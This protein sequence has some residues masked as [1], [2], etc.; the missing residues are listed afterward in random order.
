MSE[1]SPGLRE[2]QEEI[3]SLRRTTAD[4]ENIHGR[5]NFGQIP[6]HVLDQCPLTTGGKSVLI[7]LSRWWY[8]NGICFAS[9]ATM[10]RNS[11]NYKDEALKKGADELHRKGV[12]WKG[13]RMN[14]Y[15]R[16][17]VIVPYYEASRAIDALRAGEIPHDII[18]PHQ[19]TELADECADFFFGSGIGL[20][21]ERL[22]HPSLKERLPNPE[23]T[24]NEDS[25]LMSQRER[26]SLSHRERESRLY[27]LRDTGEEILESSSSP[28]GEDYKSRT[29]SHETG[30]RKSLNAHIEEISGGDRETIDRCHAFLSE[31]KRWMSAQNR[32][33]FNPRGFLDDAIASGNF[34]L[35]DEVAEARVD[36]DPKPSGRYEA[37]TL[38]GNRTYH[39]LQFFSSL[40]S[41]L[42][43]D[44]Q[45]RLRWNRDTAYFYC[46]SGKTVSVSALIPTGDFTK[47]LRTAI[48]DNGS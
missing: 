20:S 1:S 41:R 48:E 47:A 12:I 34:C 19:Q 2:L 7:E 33:M 29:V 27:L 37:A 15:G 30:R 32:V 31:S 11:R 35:R 4:L 5:G 23:P 9:Y 36:N 25:N 38:E 39:N 14:R 42:A 40:R 21:S 17:H 16:K 22:N 8:G 10:T 13:W 45:D 46:P 28:S 44:G 26:D 18:S 24:E 6:G 43:P 3:A